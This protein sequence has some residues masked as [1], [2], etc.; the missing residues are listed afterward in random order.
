MPQVTNVVPFYTTGAS[1]VAVEWQFDQNILWQ[2]ESF[3]VKWHYSVYNE[4]TGEVGKYYGSTST[5]DPDEGFNNG[6]STTRWR[7]T[8]SPPDNWYKVDINI[9]PISK[10]YDQDGKQMSYWTGTNYWCEVYAK[11][12]R[13]EDPTDTP[14]LVFGGVNTD[15]TSRLL[16]SIS[17][18][19]D[20][21]TEVEFEFHW[22]TTGGYP[23]SVY[24]TL[25]MYTR[26]GMS[27]CNINA[28]SGYGFVVR[29]RFI[30][31]N[32]GNYGTTE[33]TDY[34]DAVYTVPDAP[35]NLTAKASTKTSV[36]LSW[37]NPNSALFTNSTAVNNF[38]IEYATKREDLND[39][40][41]GGTIIQTEGL[42]TF[43]TVTGLEEGNEYFF[44]VRS[45]NDNGSSSWSNIVSV[46]LGAKPNAPT[47][48]SSSSTVI[49]GET[50][51]LYWVH[52][53]EDGSDARSS[54]LELTIGTSTKTIT[55]ANPNIDDDDDENETLVYSIDTGQYTE[56]T[57]V[58]WRVRTSG[59]TEEYG[60][61]SVRRTV[62]IYA[63]PTVVV[64]LLDS[65]GSTVSTVTSFPLRVIG[66]TS[67]STQTPIG[68]SVSITSNSTYETYTDVGENLVV[69]KG[70]VI[71][72]KYINSK[73]QLD[74]RLSA[75]DVVLVSGSSYTIEVVA[76]MDSGLSATS[77]LTIDVSLV[78]T[79]YELN[80]RMSFDSSNCTMY[81]IPYCQ[82]SDGSLAIGIDM[83]V[84]R[85]EYDGSL[86]LIAEGLNSSQFVG[87]T[88]PHPSLSYARYRLVATDRNT[89]AMTF[90]DTPAYP[91]QEKC[92]IIQWDERWNSFNGNENGVL[93]DPAWNGSVVKLPYNI[94]IQENTSSEVTLVNYIGR[95][96][97]VSYYGTAV[98]SSSSWSVSVPMYDEELLFNLRR[99]SKWTGDVYVREPSGSGYWANVAV[100]FTRN[101]LETAMPVTI[102]VTRVSG[103][104]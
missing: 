19:D 43:Y 66:T 95:A 6:T 75:G 82:E 102:D 64:G 39:S 81:L 32:A 2:T 56:G 10:T 96:Y 89:G 41:T 14:S 53:S 45:V 51:N 52:N 60:D 44:R 3:E 50:L 13:P 80:T 91:V 90:Y 26:D 47:T 1:N 67:P 54:E 42:N 68:Y 78:D 35:T 22:L 31:S 83:S 55:I 69:N 24:R 84:Y 79:E 63:R 12:T 21:V 38:E 100:S 62:D 33:W 15:G 28:P 29:C 5:I 104:M 99:L 25:K 92:I 72:E 57:K 98:S 87:I 97:P 93:A 36:Y 71:F 27:S 65:S 37:K 76:S 49:V 59:I 58:R 40:S 23:G 86:T 4:F 61:W 101:H 7:A 34:S 73:A 48:W 16:A 70:D 74:L 46:I 103:G 9:M 8:Y 85:I 77:S 18:P 30:N 11:N 20:R 94:D 88:D 17:V